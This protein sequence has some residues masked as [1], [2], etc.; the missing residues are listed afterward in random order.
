MGADEDCAEFFEVAVVFVF[1]FGYTPGVLAPLT[2]RPSGV[3]TSRSEPMTEKGMA[4]IKLRACWRP[5][6]SSS[7]RGG[8]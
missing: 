4:A 3:E 1:D 8:V 6:S 5:G 7:S 2:V